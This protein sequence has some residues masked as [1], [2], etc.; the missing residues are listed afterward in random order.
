[1]SGGTIGWRKLL[2]SAKPRAGVPGLPEMLGLSWADAPIFIPRIFRD[3]RHRVAFCGICL[4]SRSAKDESVCAAQTVFRLVVMGAPS[5]I[6]T[7]AHG[8]GG[9]HLL[10][11]LPA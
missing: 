3:W 1:M 6:R 7:Y 10:P 5:R 9:R 11:S 4:H 8:S 2:A